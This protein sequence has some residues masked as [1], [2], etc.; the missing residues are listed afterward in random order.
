M[1][2]P[3]WT[4]A[5]DQLLSLLECPRFGL[6]SD[7]DG[8]LSPFVLH[9]DNAKIR[10]ENVILLDDLASRLTV[11]ALVSGRG[12]L[13]LRQRFER[14]YLVYYG[15]HGMELWQEGGVRVAESARI[16]S[17]QLYTLLQE[18]NTDDLPGVVVEYK[19]VTASVHYR[20]AT[21]PKV[22]SMIIRNR[23]T[24]LIEQHGLNLSEGS[25]VFEIKPP[26]ALNKGTAVEAIINQYHL[27]SVLFLGDDR[28]DIEAMHRM[29][30]LAADPL[31][32]LRVLSVGVIHPTTLPELFDHCDVTANGVEEVTDLLLWLRDHLRV[33]QTDN[34]ISQKGP[35]S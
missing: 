14:P 17:Q 30:Q 8:T 20:M 24:P 12:A 29:R 15:N 28:T 34:P 19:E 21:N 4:E 1:Q 27:D 2:V 35:A 9:P 3:H 16:W 5:E 10:P 25:Y 18:F 6:I 22:M 7:F 32:D 23:L 11:I 26:V 33:P 31:R 13:N